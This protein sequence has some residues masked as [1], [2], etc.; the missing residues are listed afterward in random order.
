MSVFR[1]SIAIAIDKLHDVGDCRR[2]VAA[3]AKALDFGETTEGKTAL[4]VTELAT[5]LVK[6]GGGGS[7]IVRGLPSAEYAGIEILSLDKGPGMDVERCLRD[8]YSTTGSP[9]TGLG[10]ISRL[11]NT[12]DIYSL[13]GKGTVLAASLWQLP[14]GKVAPELDTGAVCLPIHG[15]HRCGDGW[16]LHQSHNRVRMMVSDGLGHGDLAAEV[17][18]L[19]VATFIAR[20]DLGPGELLHALN[21][22]LKPTRGAAMAVLDI[23]LE[24]DILTFAG[25]GNIGACL[26]TGP[27]SRGMVSMNGIVGHQMRRVSE[28]TY[29]CGPD[30]VVMMHSDGVSPRWRMEDYPG[31]AF[32]SANLIAGTFYRDFGRLKD[33]ATILTFRR[34]RP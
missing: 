29:P 22:V 33:D 13:P 18:D 12:L 5:N 2:Q 28:F 27:R 4:V 31:L 34:R 25:I 15:E 23:D 3:L 1:Q 24:T 26:F 19:A 6:H 8:G 9:G 20:D 14:F 10:A 16:G 21:L 7:I 30:D 11:A 32:R 17:S